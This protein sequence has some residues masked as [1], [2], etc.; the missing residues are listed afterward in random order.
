MKDIYSM[1]KQEDRVQL[2]FKNPITR[3]SLSFTMRNITLEEAYSKFL[4]IAKELEKQD[5]VRL[6]IYNTKNRP[7][8]IENAKKTI[9]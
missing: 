2:Q 3:Q 9:N 7:K 8:V 5:E 4:F 1:V 6:T